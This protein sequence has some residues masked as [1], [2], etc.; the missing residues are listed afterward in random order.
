L[1]VSRYLSTHDWQGQIKVFRETYRERRDAMLSA[2]EQ[3]M[4]AGC[5]WTKPD[6]GFYFWLTVPEGVN[7]KAMLPRAITARVAYA[8][9]TGFYA[10][11]LGSR[12]MRLSFCYPTPER[13]HE[14]VRRLAN[15][16]S[17]EMELYRTFGPVA[18][19]TVSG[20]QSPSPDTA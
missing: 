20:P 3:Y 8:S 13:I 11:Q 5:S 1:I 6:G 15:V 17:D 16:L 9:G 4:P 12:Q 10:D 19:R 18:Q 14:G 2:L 7:T